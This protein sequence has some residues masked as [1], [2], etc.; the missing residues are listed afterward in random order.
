MASVKHLTFNFSFSAFDFHSFAFTFQY[1]EEECASLCV[2]ND[3]TLH[4][5]IDFCVNLCVCIV[6][7]CPWLF[8][9]WFLAQQLFDIFFEIITHFM[10]QTIRRI[11]MLFNLVHIKNVKKIVLVFNMVW[12]VFSCWNSMKTRANRLKFSFEARERTARTSL[13]RWH[14]TIECNQMY[15]WCIQLFCQ[16]GR[17]YKS[18]IVTASCFPMEWEH[19]NMKHLSVQTENV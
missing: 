11:S 4:I 8:E 7:V 14:R 16:Y 1:T 5:F 18:H 15:I 2:C 10:H 12:N 6:G 17:C 9:C 13:C 19:W 3:H